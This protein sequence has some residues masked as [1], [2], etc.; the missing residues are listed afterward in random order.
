[1]TL[2]LSLLLWSTALTL[3]LAIISV[4]GAMP[5]VGLKTL[6]ENREAMPEIS[7]WGGRANRAHRNL[8]ENLTLFAIL[9]LVAEV[10]G[11]STPQTVLGAHLF[12]WGRV[13]HAVV[14]IIGLPWVRTLAWL[15]SVAGMGMIFVELV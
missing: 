5:E 15:V 11:I 14:Y 8:L 3:V 12:F 13:A 1:M 2:E 7:G 4:L 10:L 9:V 6:V